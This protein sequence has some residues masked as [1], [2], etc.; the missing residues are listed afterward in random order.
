MLY[1][2][3][4]SKILLWVIKVLCLWGSIDHLGINITSA[5]RQDTKVNNKNL[6]NGAMLTTAFIILQW[7]I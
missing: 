6:R 1:V 2:I 4:A 5:L 7:M 3:L